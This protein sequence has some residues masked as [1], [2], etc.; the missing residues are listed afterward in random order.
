VLGEAGAGDEAMALDNLYANYAFESRCSLVYELDVCKSTCVTLLG[1]DD[2]DGEPGELLGDMRS[3]AQ[4][5]YALGAQNYEK[6]YSLTQLLSPEFE[7]MLC[8]ID[9]LEGGVG[10]ALDELE[11]AVDAMCA[12]LRTMY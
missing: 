7:R 11:S 8:A 5:Y 6:L 12:A 10:S 4:E 3:C 2:Y 1:S 9:E